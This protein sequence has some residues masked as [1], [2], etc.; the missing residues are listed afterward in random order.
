[1]RVATALQIL[2]LLVSIVGM[3]LL[4]LREQYVAGGVVVVVAAFLLVS[5]WRTAMLGP[6]RV[7]SVTYRYHILDA[8]AER[9]E[10]TKTK[11]LIARQ[12]NITTVV[13]RNIAASG[14][15]EFVRSNLGNIHPI[16]EGGSW[17]VYTNLRS[18]LETNKETSHS[19]EYVGHRSFEDETE[20]I[21]C[22]VSERADEVVLVVRFPEDRKPVQARVLKVNRFNQLTPLGEPTVARD[23]LELSYSITKPRIGQKYLIEWDWLPI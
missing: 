2:G 18:A 7:R 5:V 9:T 3:A 12:K 20:S 4:F 15:V 23:G 21:G 8:A 22:I 16:N 17:T 14:R 6:L 13:D 11:V 19:L 1:M 10:V